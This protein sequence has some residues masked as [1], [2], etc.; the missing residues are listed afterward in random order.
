MIPSGA[1]SSDGL[2]LGFAKSVCFPRGYRN[3]KL[4]L[5]LVYEN[6]IK[7]PAMAFI[8]AI[9]GAGVTSG[10][11]TVHSSPVQ[12]NRYCLCL[13]ATNYPHCVHP[14]ILLPPVIKM[15]CRAHKRLSLEQMIT[16]PLLLS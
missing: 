15:R 5:D 7:I 2:S 3:M 16:M 8:R 10:L 4:N 9:S 11:S 14:C 6:K 12:I 1:C 13:D